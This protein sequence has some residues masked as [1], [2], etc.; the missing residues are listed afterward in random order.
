MA[1][2]PFGILALALP[3]QVSLE[4][5]RFQQDG[6]DLDLTYITPQIIAMGFPASG[7]EAVYR[8]IMLLHAWFMPHALHASCC[9]RHVSC[10][11]VY[12]AIPQVAYSNARR[13]LQHVAGT[14]STSA[15]LSSTLATL[16]GTVCTT[17]APNATTTT[18]GAL[19]PR[20]LT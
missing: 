11:M 15:L 6:F 9:R 10:C 19:N 5:K 20:A 14:T 4:K 1:L 3:L 7:K 2:C 18:P 16:V 12:A 8:C 17:S 13:M